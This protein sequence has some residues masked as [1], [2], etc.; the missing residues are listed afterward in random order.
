VLN[1]RALGER[2]KDDGAKFMADNAR[3]PGVVTTESGLQYR[4]LKTGTGARPFLNNTVLVNYRGTLPDGTE[5]DTSPAD[6]PAELVVA[7][8]VPGFKEALQLMP[9]GSVWQLVL[10]ANL[11]YGDRGTGADVGPNQVLLFDVELVGIK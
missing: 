6:R 5:F 10:P 7:Q 9:A 8:M 4:I 2:N 11:A 1:R 3:R